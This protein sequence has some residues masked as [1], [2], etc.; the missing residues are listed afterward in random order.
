MKGINLRGYTNDLVVLATGLFFGW[1]VYQHIEAYRP[2]LGILGFVLF[3]AVGLYVASAC[4][5]E[6]G[7]GSRLSDED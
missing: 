2:G 7:V 4:L 1:V 3:G 5:P 6:S